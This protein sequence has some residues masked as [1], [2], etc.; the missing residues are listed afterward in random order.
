MTHELFFR[1][2]LIISA[3][4]LF[5]SIQLITRSMPKVLKK[6][7]YQLSRKLMGWAFSVLPIISVLYFFTNIHNLNQSYSTALNLCGYYPTAALIHLSFLALI[8]EKLNL[9]SRRFVIY[10][11][12]FALLPLYFW[13]GFTH[14]GVERTLIIGNTLLFSSLAAQFIH[15][16]VKFKE[17]KLGSKGKFKKEI[18]LHIKWIR[19]SI[20]LFAI[21]AA[22]ACIAPAFFSY[23]A[24]LALFYSGYVLAIFIYIYNSYQRFI[25]EYHSFT[26]AVVA[27]GNAHI[28]LID[29]DNNKPVLVN[30]DQEPYTSIARNLHI[31][32]DEK[33]YCKVGITINYVAS[34]LS[35]NRTYLSTYINSTYQ[36]SF[37]VWLTNLRIEEAKRLMCEEKSYSIGQIAEMSGFSSLTSF[38]NVFRKNEG[39]PP[40][41]WRAEHK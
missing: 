7:P 30:L 17:V 28:E 18:A 16:Y 41:R 11:F 29:E 24:W 2:Q 6:T 1:A 37:K 31:W 40:S 21:L 9:R 36:Y 15:F 19:K 14:K 5:L 12:S 34:E 22:I 8:G 26:L 27:D 25:I 10:M 3:I 20:Y 13:Y 35:T 39:I 33:G 38:I 23:S 4:I 32:V